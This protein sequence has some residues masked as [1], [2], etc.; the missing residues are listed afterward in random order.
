MSVCLTVKVPD[1][2]DTFDMDFIDLQ[3]LQAF[4]NSAALSAPNNS[5]AICSSSG[6]SS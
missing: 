2:A 5:V 6:Q 1:C 4:S 3:H